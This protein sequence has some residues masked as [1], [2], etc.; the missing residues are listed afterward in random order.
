MLIS[1]AIQ[2]VKLT[3]AVALRSVQHNL[4]RHLLVPQ[5]THGTELVIVC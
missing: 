5:G 4:A 2:S 1:T 3:V